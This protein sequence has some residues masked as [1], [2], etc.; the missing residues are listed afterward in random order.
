[1]NIT[2][3]GKTTAL[4]ETLLARAE[5]R[6]LSTLRGHRSVGGLRASLYNAFPEDGVKL[7]VALL[8]DVEH[9]R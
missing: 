1:M 3:R 2:F 7:L 6:G 8:D 5:E 9:G 4:E